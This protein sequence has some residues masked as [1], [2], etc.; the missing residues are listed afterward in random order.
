MRNSYFSL[1]KTT[2]HYGKPWRKII[3]GYY[4]AYIIAQAVLGLSPYAFGR[5]IDVLQNFNPSRLNEVIFWLGF[6]IAV[7]FVFWVF[8]GPARVI[9]RIVALKIQQSFRLSI[10]QQLTCLPLQWHQNHHSGNIITRLNRAT[11]ALRLFAENQ[12]IYIETIVRFIVS[13]A[14][15]FWLSIPIGLFSLLASGVI[16]IIIV[17]FDK[18]LIPLY[19]TQNDIDNHIGAVLFD[20]INNMTTVLTLRFGKLTSSNLWHRMLKIWPFFNR[21]VVLNESKWFIMMMLLR[22]VNLK[23][24]LTYLL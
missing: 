23:I 16:I 11:L 17:L 4:C 6:S 18:Q 19:D 15:L 22:L 21:D 13:I 12:Y 1:L 20:Y 24:Q 7:M 3:I 10:Y 5:A 8:H 14:F 9:E 2:W